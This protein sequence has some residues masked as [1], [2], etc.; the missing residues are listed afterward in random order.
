MRTLSLDRCLDLQDDFQTTEH[1]DGQCKWGN[2]AIQVPFCRK[3]LLRGTWCWAWAALGLIGPSR[4]ALK[5]HG[6]GAPLPVISSHPKVALLPGTGK[7]PQLTRCWNS[8][9]G[10]SGRPP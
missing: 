7:T 9:T 10:T 8:V 1:L 6:G 4:S 2:E 5:N 3:S